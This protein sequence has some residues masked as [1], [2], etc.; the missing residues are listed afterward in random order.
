MLGILA[1]NTLE[2]RVS[3]ICPR[4][5]TQVYCLVCV[6]PMWV[7]VEAGRRATGPAVGS[8]GPGARATGEAPGCAKSKCTT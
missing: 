5:V 1:C 7:L 3:G 4:L 8:R 2:T 6:L